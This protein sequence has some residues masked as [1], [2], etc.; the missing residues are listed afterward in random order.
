MLSLNL[1]NGV[2][3]NLKYNT[4]A[5]FIFIMIQTSVLQAMEPTRRPSRSPSGNS[6]SSLLL[7]S[8]E[9]TRKT[10]TQVPAE[11]TVC[12]EFPTFPEDVLEEIIENCGYKDELTISIRKLINKK[13]QYLQVPCMVPR[14]ATHQEL[15]SSLSK[16]LIAEPNM[17]S[18][19]KGIL[20]RYIDSLPDKPD[21][22]PESKLDNEIFYSLVKLVQAID[23]P[24][25]KYDLSVKMWNYIEIINLT[26]FS[27]EQIA[28]G[29]TQRDFYL[30]KEF[31][32]QEIELM[33]KN[34][35]EN[36]HREIKNKDIIS[37]LFDETR[38]NLSLWILSA[39]ENVQREIA[40]K[41]KLAGVRLMELKN[42][43]G[44]LQIN[45]ALAHPSVGRHKFLPEDDTSKSLESYVSLT[46]SNTDYIIPPLS[47]VMR[48]FF[49][50][51]DTNAD[52]EMLH[53][54]YQEYRINARYAANELSAPE[55]LTKFLTNIKTVPEEVL[56]ELSGL[57]KYDRFTKP[58][59]SVKCDVMTWKFS[60]YAYF[61]K[62]WDEVDLLKRL[63]RNHFFSYS[64]LKEL[65]EGVPE[66][67]HALML[68]M[69][70]NI[71][72]DLAFNL[73]KG[74]VGSC[75][76]KAKPVTIREKKPRKKL[77]NFED[78][79]DVPCNVE[80]KIRTRADSFSTS[81]PSEPSA[82]NRKN[83][84][85]SVS[86]GEVDDSAL[87]TAPRTRG[88]EKKGLGRKI[89]KELINSRLKPKV[90]PQ[91]IPTD[92]IP[93]IEIN[94]PN[95]GSAPMDDSMLDGDNE[96]MFS[97]LDGFDEVIA[98][99][100]FLPREKGEKTATETKVE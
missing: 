94:Q 100:K 16:I 32:D 53:R 50:I 27:G 89:S 5:P 72:E 31:D 6:I 83:S 47:I 29:I 99:L 56:F 25:L 62:S 36:K 8:K 17:A 4:L 49:N 81:D 86:S 91:K 33:L 88:L 21:S 10:E 43:F 66:A 75:I 18:Q 87:L 23:E 84:G 26:L 67:D 42:A 82:E 51:S 80:P 92:I 85:D 40:N 71:E 13:S 7:T 11:V 28:N 65:C 57:I 60:D 59:V 39:D 64:Q 77:V 46:A 98:T 19:I 69:W 45:G 78:L 48:D 44:L 9:R 30:L 54:K 3:M 14:A 41:L 70:L 2:E 1:H 93:V 55:C 90:S 61:F 12:P 52:P 76:Q 22:S 74:E 37:T 63:V 15:I 58:Q 68:S 38:N 96:N 20:K 79:T 24:Q 97:N 34:H 73:L 95:S 35:K